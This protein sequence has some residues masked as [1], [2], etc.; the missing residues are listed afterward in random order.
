[1]NLLTMS[2]Y[3]VTALLLLA[4]AWMNLRRLTSR[5]KQRAAVKAAQAAGQ[6]IESI[7]NLGCSSCSHCHGCPS[8]SQ[9]RS[10]S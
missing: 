3:L 7:P 6:P 5:L 9:C 4:A 8:A 10:K 1:M 2:P